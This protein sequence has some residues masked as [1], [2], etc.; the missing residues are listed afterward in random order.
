ME[1]P[2]PVSTGGPSL[3]HPP[4]GP[5]PRGGVSARLQGCCA[6]K[7]GTPPGQLVSG[8]SF[9]KDALGRQLPASSVPS[10]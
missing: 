2:S 6:H 9:T 5:Y 7:R 3:W 4:E 10:G 1:V 8:R